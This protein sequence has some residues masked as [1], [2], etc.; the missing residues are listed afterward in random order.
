MLRAGDRWMILSFEH[1][2]N[3]CWKYISFPPL[4]SHACYY[5]R[6]LG[7][8]SQFRKLG[9]G[10]VDPVFLPSPEFL[11]DLEQ[12]EGRSIYWAPVTMQGTSYLTSFSPHNGCPVLCPSYR[13]ENQGTERL[14]NLLKVSSF[15]PGL[16][17]RGHVFRIIQLL[18]WSSAS[19]RALNSILAIVGGR[20]CFVRD[21]YALG[22]LV[23][24]APAPDFPP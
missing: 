5:F 2:F 15:E 18:W 9:G 20:N 13:W 21:T 8:T 23:A 7:K 1:T 22:L 6:M 12:K 19:S 11:L 14:R 3:S 4:T 24:L 16:R 10:T 17:C